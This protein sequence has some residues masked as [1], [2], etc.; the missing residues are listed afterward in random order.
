MLVNAS[1]LDKEVEDSSCLV[2]VYLEQFPGIS[3]AEPAI[4]LPL[5]LQQ[6]HVLEEGLRMQSA[7]QTE[8]VGRRGGE[9]REEREVME[10][11]ACTVYCKVSILLSRLVLA[12][13]LL[14]VERF[15]I[16]VSPFLPSHSSS[17]CGR[18]DEVTERVK[19]RMAPVRKGREEEKEGGREGDTHSGF[20][21]TSCKKRDSCMGRGGWDHMTPL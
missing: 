17:L 13:Q 9:G 8:L 12:S 19:Q 11:E 15:Q 10:D 1:L 20:L 7:L 18:S 21:P 6:H 4:A 14:T 16:S 2:H 3:Q 5:P